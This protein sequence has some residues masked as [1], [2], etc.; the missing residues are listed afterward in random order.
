MTD[1]DIRRWCAQHAAEQKALLMRLACIPAPSHHEE[2]RA[3][4]I[5]DWLSSRGI[6]ATLDVAG[7]VVV[8][9]NCGDGDRLT[10]YAAHMDVVFL[11]GMSRFVKNRTHLCRGGQTCVLG[12][13][14]GI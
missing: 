13:E 4:F 3:A 14:G 10:L 2:K 1:R 6:A 9:I 8:M 5:M 12:G 11:G 7:N